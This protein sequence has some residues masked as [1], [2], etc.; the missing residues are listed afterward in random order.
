MELEHQL[1]RAYRFVLPLVMIT[2]K[3]SAGADSFRNV[4]LLVDNAGHLPVVTRGV[5]GGVSN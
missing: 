4:F 2:P 3:D 1:Q 5:P